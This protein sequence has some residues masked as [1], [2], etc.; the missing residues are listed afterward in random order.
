M[1]DTSFRNQ[2]LR[3]K[4]WQSVI[5]LPKGPKHCQFPRGEN[6]KTKITLHFL[7]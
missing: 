4:I 1:I 6:K 5:L 2:L 7:Q 3:N